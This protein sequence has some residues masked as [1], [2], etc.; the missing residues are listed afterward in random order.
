MP[1]IA[2]EGYPFIAGSALVAAG[3]WTWAGASG[4]PVPWSATGA[5]TALALFVAYFFRDPEREPPE[6]PALALAPGDGLVVEIARD[7]G[8]PVLGGPCRRISIFL[9]VFDVHVQR[10]P[11]AGRVVHRSYEPGGYAIAWKPKA[12]E[13]NERATLGVE[14]DA[15]RVA[16]RQ[17][18]GLVA[19]RIVTYPVEGDLL[20]RGQ[21]I[22][23]IRFGSRVDTFVPLGWTVECQVGDRARA[24]RTPLARIPA[25]EGEGS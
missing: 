19:R 12:S 25:A 22:G 20:E 7:D 21:R 15:G 16:V 5:G 8:P 2:R 18:A 9:S 4:G 11:V 3:L 6:D 10:S 1:R 24:G 23:L 13:E 14:T 17:I